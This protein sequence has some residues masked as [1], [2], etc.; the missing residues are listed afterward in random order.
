MAMQQSKLHR[1]ILVGAAL[2]VLLGLLVIFGIGFL[3]D[4][5]RGA[6]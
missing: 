2:A 1:Y 3:I 4:S 5:L 6:V